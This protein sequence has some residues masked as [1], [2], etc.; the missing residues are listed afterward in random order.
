MK[1]MSKHTFNDMAT[2]FI[3]KNPKNLSSPLPLSLSVTSHPLS[4]C[5]FDE[6]HVKNLQR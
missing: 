3:L 1:K 2:F 6:I 5:N 4:L